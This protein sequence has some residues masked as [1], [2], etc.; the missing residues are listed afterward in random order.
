MESSQREGGR[1]FEIERLEKRM[2]Q[3]MELEIKV[4]S[5]WVYKE[6]IS[7]GKTHLTKVVAIGKNSQEGKQ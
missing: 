7:R 5:S 4:V 6:M 1:T 2:H 3:S